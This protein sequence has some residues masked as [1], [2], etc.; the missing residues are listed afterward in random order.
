MSKRFLSPLR[1]VNL[2][3][4]PAGGSEGDIYWNSSSNKV[5]VYQDGSWSDLVQQSATSA[6]Q[7]LSDAPN[8][9]S[10]G[11]IYFNS[12]EQT[13]K[14]YNGNLWYDVGGPKAILDHYHNTSDG[15]VEHVDY[16][17]YVEEQLVYMD[18]GNASTSDFFDIINGGSA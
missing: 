3:S 15:R 9:P 18:G 7:V 17:T 13:I 16:E 4:D 6:L 5:R 12:S 2:T 8:S 1:L 11:T 14:I 10:Q